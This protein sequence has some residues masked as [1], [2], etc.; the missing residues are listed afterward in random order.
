MHK[1]NFLLVVDFQE[2]ISIMHFIYLCF[3]WGWRKIW[4][5]YWGK[6]LMENLGKIDKIQFGV[7]GKFYGICQFYNSLLFFSSPEK[8]NISGSSLQIF[9]QFSLWNFSLQV[10]SE[11]SLFSSIFYSIFSLNSLTSSSICFISLMALL[12]LF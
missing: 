8:R 2:F 10:F 1:F 7:G 4:E 3:G 12:D 5:I 6:T 11:I 9:N